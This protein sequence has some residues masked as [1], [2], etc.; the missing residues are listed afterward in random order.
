MFSL[1]SVSTLQQTIEA[2]SSNIKS[3]AYFTKQRNF[4]TNSVHAT[5]NSVQISEV[6]NYYK[7]DT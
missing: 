3:Q 2:N 7:V 4:N 6:Y 1:F 5:V